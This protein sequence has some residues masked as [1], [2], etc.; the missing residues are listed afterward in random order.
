ML[1]RWRNGGQTVDHHLPPELPLP[2]KPTSQVVYEHLLFIKWVLKRKV[3]QKN[4]GVEAF[5]GLIDRP[6]FF[7]LRMGGWVLLFRYLCPELTYV[8]VNSQSVFICSPPGTY[9]TCSELRRSWR[10]GGVGEVHTWSHC[11]KHLFVTSV[12]TS[13]RTTTESQVKWWWSSR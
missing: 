8:N 10:G 9:K 1:S 13:L 11:N 3:M 2:R 12:G 5:W 6:N 4:E 7:D